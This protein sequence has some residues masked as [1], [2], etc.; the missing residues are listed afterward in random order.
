M[1][2]F[3]ENGIKIKMIETDNNTIAVD[4]PQDLANVERLMRIDSLVKT[5]L[6]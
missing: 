4:T 6:N 1:N 3:I 5:Y 2:R